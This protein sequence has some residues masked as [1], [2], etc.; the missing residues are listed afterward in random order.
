MDGEA[1]HRP[2][3]HGLGSWHP[4]HMP[5]SSLQESHSQS[6][7]STS[8]NSPRNDDS[9]ATSPRYVPSV[10]TPMAQDQVLHAKTEPT[11]IDRTGV[12]ERSPSLQTSKPTSDSTRQSESY[13]GGESGHEG[14]GAS[15][16]VP[17]DSNNGKQDT[18]TVNG[19][20]F[21]NDDLNN[22]SGF[23]QE[24]SEQLGSL[25]RSNSFP[26]VPPLHQFRKL[27]GQAHGQ[28]QVESILEQEEEVGDMSQQRYDMGE[29]Q[30][31]D[32]AEAP[33]ERYSGDEEDDDYKNFAG[34]AADTDA[35]NVAISPPDDEA[36]F[37]E[38]LPL[39]QSGSSSLE[40]PGEQPS[41]VEQL[42]ED[43]TTTDPEFFGQ[44]VT[45][46]FLTEDYTTTDQDFFAQNPQSS[47]GDASFKP[48]V[49]DRKSTGQVLQSMSFPPRHITHDTPA[50]QA[51]VPS[52][53]DAPGGEFTASSSPG[54]SHGDT[55]RLHL[56]EKLP[57]RGPEHGPE[58]TDEDLAAMWQAALDD[59][60][61]L[62]DIETPA[63]QP[64]LDHSAST[65][66]TIQ[67]SHG[68]A[69]QT[70]RFGNA[71]AD[72]SLPVNRYSPASNQQSQPQVFQNYIP[73]GRQQ[74]SGPSASYLSHSASAPGGFGQPAAQ[75]S[76]PNN[77]SSA[78]RPDMPKPA[79]SFADKSKGGYT[80]PYDLPMDVSR[81]KRRTNLQQVQNASN[82][83]MSPQPPPPPRN[84]SMYAAGS[85]VTDQSPP[86]PPLPSNAS[87]QP[88]NRPSSSNVRTKTSVGSFFEEL[89]S[90]TKPRPS[91]AGKY[92]PAAPPHLSGQIPPRPEAARPP[93]SAQRPPLTS[94]N[95]TPNLQLAPPERHSPYANLPQHDITSNAP[96]QATSR[97]SP[98]PGQPSNVPPS[99]N[100]YAASPGVGP[101]PA[102]PP[103]TTTF[104]PRTSSPLAQ[105]PSHQQQPFR[106][107]SLP[108]G[109]PERP[110]P[111]QR[112]MTAQRYTSSDHA[113]ALPQL[114][115]R[116][117]PN[118]GRNVPRTP[119]EEPPTGPMYPQG[120]NQLSPSGGYGGPYRS[121]PSG[122]AFSTFTSESEPLSASPH[123]QTQYPVQS[124]PQMNV[125]DVKF[126]PPRRSQ[127]Q[128]PGAI[129]PK[130]E[131]VNRT[132][133]VHQRPASAI[134]GQSHLR[135]NPPYPSSYAPAARNEDASRK[136]L[137]YIRPVDG[138]ESDPLERWK[139]A[140]I[141]KFGFG[142]N[143]VTSFPKHVPRYAAGHAFPM[144]SCSPGEVKL[145]LGNVGTLDNDLANF[146]GPLKSKGKKK[147]LLGWLQQKI[148]ALENGRAFIAPS[149]QLPDPSKR[150]EEKILLWRIMY[151][152]I[153]HDGSI[154]RN[155]KAESAVRA[156][157]S[158]ESSK[159][160]VPENTSME[161]GG[162]RPSISKPDGSHPV[163]EST[164]AHAM[165]SV[166]RLLL[167]GEREKAVWLAVDRRMWAHAMV[168]ASTLEK[169]IWKQVLHEFTRLEV[170]PFGDNTES[171]AAVYEVFAGNWE[172]SIDELVPPS[173]RA[174]LQMVSKAASTGPTRNALDGLDKW[175]ETLALILSNR[176][177]EDE[178]ALAALGRLLAGY[179]RTEAA[180]ICLI[181]AKSAGLFG[182]S[183]DTQ[184]ANV[185]LLGADHQQ[186]PLDFGRDL[187]SI[188]LTEVYEFGRSILAPT[189]TL[190]V[191]PHLQ[192]YKLYHAM[193]LAEHGY[194]VEAQQY[195][196]AVLSTLKSTTKPSPYYHSL[197]FT[198]LD[199]L[200][201]R[202]QQAPRDGSSWMSKP[203]DKV[204]GSMWKKFNNFIA[205]DE[206]DTASVASGKGEQDAGPFARVTPDPSSM[207]RSESTTDLYAAYGSS[208]GPPPPAATALGS[209]YA[210]SGPYAPAG[211][212][213]PRS[214]LE[215]HGRSSEDSYRP[216][217][218]SSLRPMQSQNP[219]SSNSS[220]YAS[221]P[222][223]LEGTSSHQ[224]TPH[225]QSST[226]ASQQPATYLPTPPT[227]PDSM[228]TAPLND[229]SVSLYPQNT[230][231]TDSPP[232]SQAP[233]HQSSSFEGPYNNTYEAPQSSYDPSVSAY[234]PP[235]SYA[236]YSPGGQED[237]SLAEPKSPKK[238][239]SFMYDDDDDEFNSKAGAV[240]KDE[241]ARKDKE[242]DD[243]FRKAA[244][245][246]AQKD[247]K[248][249][250]SGWFGGVGGWL[251]GSKK[252]EQNLNQ[253]PKAIKA[254]LGEESSFVYD[255]ELK[256][257]VNKKDP[258]STATEAPKPP[259]PRGPPSRAVSAAGGPPPSMSRTATPPVPPLPHS[260]MPTQGPT[261]PMNVTQSTP[262]TNN[263]PS[264]PPS[265]VG[266]PARTAS[267]AGLGAN[268]APTGG[269]PS[270]PPSRPSTAA[271]GASKG[272]D[273]DDLLGEP[274]VRKG[275][276][277]KRGKKG[278][279]YVDVMAK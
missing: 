26:A 151:I 34:I 81:P 123:A 157:L 257:W 125:D 206:S 232:R 1:D 102:A 155:G 225:H 177:P 271:G 205:G 223:N 197:L 222:A 228:A 19:L 48:A 192:S 130:P 25:D 269:P 22:D 224:Y 172:E 42:N 262:P 176:T 31:N 276:T 2:E 195:C 200:L 106:K 164:D 260:T 116:F 160:E 30:P 35:G 121:S 28:S 132:Q 141:F 147:E 27:D 65:S 231:Q 17:S 154:T 178:S 104:Q 179:G 199:D 252:D 83:R 4:A 61:L 138:R 203:M 9:K 39:V 85:P 244:E 99:R 255:K 275:G 236:P 166:R 109:A 277:M 21:A 60:D 101:R 220:R 241:K 107:G 210:P 240:L 207:S 237:S 16:E 8:R 80:S 198:S 36:R 182:G 117:E 44:E 105:D 245:A 57:E 46:E 267:P 56:A 270:A 235:S 64:A 54:T 187:D 163:G 63:E 238:K 5:E 50:W 122:S 243:A 3:V 131:A 174:G 272:S 91:S 180:H 119:L 37:E 196:D 194:R 261:P 265:G 254:K 20:S 162:H 142:G 226:Y 71:D 152:F 45:S 124:Q 108:N 118:V 29:P 230:H 79:Q 266:T 217:Q 6:T 43:S 143:I 120:N 13:D 165:E 12:A 171:L 55:D 128:S 191:S 52:L 100:R 251:G 170:K 72:P 15:L 159:G 161:L 279:G 212:Y 186:Q 66:S 77:V 268:L 144:V 10:E 111:S 59:D 173:A 169:K 208:N 23:S 167:Q 278:R 103:Q 202:L 149:S 73:A 150:H 193:L 51:E 227:Q 41:P 213:T 258:A 53:S 75:Q 110:P 218:S 139:G 190:S 82:P 183:D 18:S 47:Q 68:S 247:L 135:A 76:L 114:E 216:S 49:L 88:P 175:Q 239:K 70:H 234:E 92:T 115:E 233:P 256:K 248:P 127:T 62:D 129:R 98:A 201:E 93:P 87:A 145:R 84:T 38:G 214:S 189:A 148:A 89:P 69:R 181:F 74:I 211:Q 273:I 242:A 185:V 113:A 33:L 24:M 67:G 188:L 136:D 249:K 219:Y 259:P 156:V 40:P 209:R 253:E 94:S 140:P 126:E 274:Q 97:Y 7:D 134:G 137:E 146:P 95:T 250:K 204:S 229:P 86:L 78:A 96:L 11:A 153:E 215:Q 168:L 221:S 263:F 90:T 184:Q 264:G 158:P 58:Q 112:S 133:A 14:P 32:T 246:D